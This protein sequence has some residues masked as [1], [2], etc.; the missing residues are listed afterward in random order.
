MNNK[1]KDK[2]SKSAF[3]RKKKI[4][5]TRAASRAVRDGHPWIFRNGIANRDINHKAGDIVALHDEDSY[6][7]ATGYFE[8]E[9]AIAFRILTRNKHLDINE[10]FV[11]K[12]V[13]NAVTLRKELLIQNTN[14]Y[15]IINGESDGLPGLTVTVFGDYLLAVQYTPSIDWI[16]KIALPELAAMLDAKSVFLQKRFRPSGD[17]DFNIDRAEKFWGEDFP[18][19]FKIN[20]DGC[21]YL[22]DLSAPM[23]VGFFPDFREGRRLIRKLAPGRKM[24]NMFSHTGAFSVSAL[25]AGATRVVNIDNSG[26]YMEILRRN[27][28]NN[29]LDIDNSDDFITEDVFRGVELLRKR[30][31]SFD[32]AVVDPPTFSRGKKT[33]WSVQKSYTGLLNN[34]RY[35]MEP[36]AYLLLAINSFKISMEDFERLIA[37]SMPGR[38]MRILRRIYLPEDY[39]DL[40]FFSEGS[41][42]KSVLIRLD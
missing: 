9:G 3:S 23:G 38:S 41:Y 40:P 1:N 39:P 14:A 8:E 13:F 16:V 31:S 26:R 42:L 35:I 5:L 37:K 22:V 17:N 27:Y 36:G 32:L 34:M 33:N 12:A 11:K 4:Q 18:L 29:N 30:E 10:E 2:S 15:R 28:R 20:E 7:L 24:V 19:D 25:S 21:K 6:Y